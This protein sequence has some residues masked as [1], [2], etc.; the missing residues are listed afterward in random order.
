MGFQRAEG[1]GKIGH[2]KAY[3]RTKERTK[4]PP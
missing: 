4:L 3:R 2:S 1:W